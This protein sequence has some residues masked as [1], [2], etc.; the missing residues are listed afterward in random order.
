M[1]LPSSKRSSK[2]TGSRTVREMERMASRRCQDD[3]DLE[4]LA[5]TKPV[6]EGHE[7]ARLGR[8]RVRGGVA[9]LQ[10]PKLAQDAQDAQDGKDVLLARASSVPDKLGRAVSAPMRKGAVEHIATQPT[11]SGPFPRGRHSPDGP[12]KL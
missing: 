3:G 9:L 1:L 10:S 11:G 8:W 6:A 7:A 5:S 4:Q 12:R 2:R